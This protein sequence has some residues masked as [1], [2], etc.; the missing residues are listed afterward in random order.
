MLE[1]RSNQDSIVES[2][3]NMLIAGY[4]VVFDTPTKL[5]SVNGV[6][7]YEVVNKGALDNADMSDVVLRYN[8]ADTSTLLA[9]TTNGTLRLTVDEVG[10]FVEADLANT[11]AGKDIYELV[12]RGDLSK[13]SFAFT[14]DSDYYSLTTRYIESIKSIKDVSVVDFP[15]YQSTVVATVQRNFD[16]AEEE[17]KE[18]L[19]KEKLKT[20]L[21]TY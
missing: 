17:A 9:R 13:M 12:K 6:D 20:V 14:V 19:E 10:L 5:Y 15:A 11:T 8:H 18:N 16:K 7:Y 3:D 4:A 2:K 21:L 1:V